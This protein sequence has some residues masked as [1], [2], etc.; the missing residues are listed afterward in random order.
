VS[1]AQQILQIDNILNKVFLRLE[2]GL[3]RRAS[4]ERFEGVVAPARHGVEDVRE[5]IG[6]NAHQ[7][8]QVLVDHFWKVE[9]AERAHEQTRLGLVGLGAPD[10]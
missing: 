5:E 3:G 9:V 8:D 4:D 1:Q 7:R 2:L 6:Q 10:E